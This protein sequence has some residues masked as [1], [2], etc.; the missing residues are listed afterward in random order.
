VE[1]LIRLAGA[2]I[3]LGKHAKSAADDGPARVH[4]PA[5]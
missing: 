4:L 5:F 3:E 2:L 1:D